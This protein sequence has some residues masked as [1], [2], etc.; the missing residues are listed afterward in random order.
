[1]INVPAP[2]ERRIYVDWFRQVCQEGEELTV[3]K[4]RTRVSAERRMDGP[5]RCRSSTNALTNALT[6]ERPPTEPV[7][8]TRVRVVPEGSWSGSEAFEYGA[9]LRR[10]IVESMVDPTDRRMQIVVGNLKGPR[11]RAQSETAS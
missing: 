3:I 10:E 6:N 1:M 11:L 5:L 7:T 8:E 2:Q 9:N 4:P